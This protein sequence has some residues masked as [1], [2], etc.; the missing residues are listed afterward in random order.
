MLCREFL[1]GITVKVFEIGAGNGL[2]VMPLYVA[3]HPGN[4]IFRENAH[5]GKDH[6]KPVIRKLL[7]NQRRL[8]FK[9][10]QHIAD[11][12]LGKG[13]RRAA[14][15][16]VEHMGTFAKSF[17]YKLAGLFLIT[18]GFLQRISPRRQITVTPIAGGFRIR[19]DD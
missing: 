5:R 11:A 3:I 2:G 8:T 16:G 6:H 14:S 18:G 9:S 13:R 7:L 17:R 19:D 4:G 12:A 1:S 10:Q 15:A